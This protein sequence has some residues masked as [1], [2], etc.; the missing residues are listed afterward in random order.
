MTDYWYTLDILDLISGVTVY[1]SAIITA[2][3]EE[4]AFNQLVTWLDE[5]YPEDEFDVDILLEDN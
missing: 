1:D 3:T 2:E 5:V 4:K